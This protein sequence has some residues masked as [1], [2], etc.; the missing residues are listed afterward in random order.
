[1]QTE[2]TRLEV[3]YF[4]PIVPKE[5]SLSKHLNIEILESN[6]LFHNKSYS[7]RRP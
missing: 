7:E 3:K 4:Q 6:L 5:E 2:C 1:M